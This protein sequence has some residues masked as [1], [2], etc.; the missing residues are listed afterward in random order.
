MPKIIWAAL[1]MAMVSTAAPAQAPTQAPAQDAADPTVFIISYIEATYAGKNQV[2]TQLKQLRDA[3]AKDNG[4]IRYEVLQRVAPAN[5]FMALEI[6]KDQQAYDAHVASAHRKSFREKA[7]PLLL[8]PI[9][10]RQGVTVS[11]DPLQAAKA[12]ATA[13][14]IYV[15]SHVDVG[16]PNREKITP[17][18]KTLAETSRKDSGNLRFDVMFQKNRTNH[19]KVIEVWKDQKSDEAHEVTAHAKEFRNVLTPLSGAMYDQRWY[20]AL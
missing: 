14:A 2:A 13:S 16:P 5:Q 10:D 9:D 20:K 17:A 19:F 1:A 6:W 18:L 11:V 7:A 12:R 15:I 4:L 8:A 3:S